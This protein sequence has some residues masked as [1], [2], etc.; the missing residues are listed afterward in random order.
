MDQWP[1]TPPVEP[2]GWWDPRWE[3]ALG[4]ALAHLLAASRGA[5]VALPEGLLTQTLGRALDVLLPSG[6][7]ARTAVLAGPGLPAPDPATDIALVPRHPQT[8]EVWR[9]GGDTARVPVAAEVW[10][11][12]A[13]PHDRPLVPVAGRMPDGVLRDDPPPPRPWSLFRP[14]RRVFLGTLARLPDVRLPWSRGIH[15]RLTGQPCAR[16]FQSLFSGRH[17]GVPRRS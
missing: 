12:L 11:H 17:A 6:P 13:F 14:D 2:S 16:P 5:P 15:D 7:P 8:G 1:R 9:A 10:L 4:A 3:A